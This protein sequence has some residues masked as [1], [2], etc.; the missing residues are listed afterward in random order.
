M[1]LNAFKRFSNYK[2]EQN[3]NTEVWSYTRVSSKEQF[4]NNGSI[5]NQRDF[6]DNYTNQSR[7]Q[8]VHE[9]GGT[10]ESAKGDFTRKEFTN[11]INEIKK[12]RSKPY[13]ILIFKVSRFSRSGG[14]GI[15]IVED[16][17]TKHGVHLIET[18]TGLS[19]ETP[20]GKNAIMEKLLDAERENLERLEITIPGMQNHLKSG[21][22]LGKAPLGYDHYGPKVKDPTKYS[23][24]QRLEINDKGKLL[25]K[26]W[27]MKLAGSRDF[28][29]LKS[30]E[31]L[32]M[33]ISKQKLSDTWRNP[34]YCGVNSNS[35]LKGDVAKGNW[36]PL[37]SQTDFW[38]VQNIL[39][40][41]HSGYK[42][43]K[44]NSERPLTGFLTCSCCDQK[45]TSY[46]VKSKGLHYYSC[47]NKCEGSTVNAHSS[48]R[49]HKVGAND[50]FIDLL[51]QY[52]L[53]DELVPLFEKQL[54]LIIDNFN[55]DNQDSE[56]RIINRINELETKKTSLEEKYLFGEIELEASVFKK[57][58]DRL[59]T[60]IE[61]CKRE[62][63]NTT[64]KI[65]NQEIAVNK[66]VELSRNLRKMWVSGDVDAKLKLQKMVFPD[67]LVIDGKNRQYL[68]KKVN[69]VFARIPAMTSNSVTTNEKDPSDDSDESSL[70]AG[71]RLERATFGL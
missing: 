8:L 1:S 15:S 52:Q 56:K 24:E 34:F 20:R 58:S 4:D 21:N 19:T 71:T 14:G 9:F 31:S 3:D 16:L 27:E 50:L 41:G 25:K 39:D 67:G 54:K 30:L 17:I 5:K 64:E 51:E 70:V 7:F 23:P 26:A 35:L 68:T 38:K 29:I 44:I 13:A 42:V 32:G 33:K 69:L 60:E 66:C 22:W 40:R 43:S 61:E 46:E 63:A 45:M 36:P 37:V 11:M 62:L 18:S 65:S 55:N 28:E 6:A 59:K 49:S 47:Q 10:Y 48:N 57:H 53:S 12:K 2:D